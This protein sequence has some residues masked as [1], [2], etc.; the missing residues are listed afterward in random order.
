MRTRNALGASVAPHLFVIMGMS[1]ELGRKLGSQVYREMIEKRL[2]HNLKLIP[3]DA[4]LRAFEMHVPIGVHVLVPVRRRHTNGEAVV[5]DIEEI[6]YQLPSANS[7]SICNQLL[8][9]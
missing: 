9:C 8:K 4:M 3:F 7:Q 6:A 1:A 5:R 2:P